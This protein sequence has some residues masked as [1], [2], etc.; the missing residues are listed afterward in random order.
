MI[1][2]VC[3]CSINIIYSDMLHV[4]G[5]SSHTGLGHKIWMGGQGT[6]L[7][8]ADNWLEIKVIMLKC[9]L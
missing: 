9:V 7:N 8:P 1:E 3:K 4:S 6:S 2:N 5:G